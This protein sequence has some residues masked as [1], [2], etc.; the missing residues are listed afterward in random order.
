MA[1]HLPECDVLHIAGD[2]DGAFCICR[3]LRACE[4]RVRDEPFGDSGKALL[5]KGYVAGREDE[6][7]ALFDDEGPYTAGFNTGV[8][9]ARDAVAALAPTTVVLDGPLPVVHNVRISDALAAI[10]ALREVSE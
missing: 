3:Q 7:R 1:D 2:D 9:C 8:Q 6:R 10:D 4:Q 5:D